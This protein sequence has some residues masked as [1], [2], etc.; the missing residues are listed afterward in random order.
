[1]N[2]TLDINPKLPVYL[3]VLV[4]VQ[5]VL[6]PHHLTN[7]VH[8]QLWRPYVHRSYPREGRKDRTDGTTAARIVL[9]L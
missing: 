7:R 2:I 3:E 4:A 5:S 8:G 9:H 1:M 6:Y